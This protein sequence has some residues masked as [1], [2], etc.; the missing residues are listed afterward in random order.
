MAKAQDID[1]EEEIDACIDKTNLGAKHERVALLLVKYL[2]LL[3]FG[4]YSVV[5]YIFNDSTTIA[6]IGRNLFPPQIF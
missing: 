2:T 3:N 4:D 6:K 1:E 5:R